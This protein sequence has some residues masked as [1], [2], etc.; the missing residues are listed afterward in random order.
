MTKGQDQSEQ[1]REEMEIYEEEKKAEQ[2]IH[3]LPPRSRLQRK[4]T[5]AKKSKFRLSFPIIRL[6]LVLFIALIITALTSP[7]WLP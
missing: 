2:P 4:R 1:L 6:L 7:Y 3:S 5:K